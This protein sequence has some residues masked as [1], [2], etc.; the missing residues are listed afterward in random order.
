MSLAPERP[1]RMVS[2]Y[3]MEYNVEFVVKPIGNGHAIDEES[4]IPARKPSILLQGSFVRISL[5]MPLR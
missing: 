1:A 2:R 3:S 4:M 5:D